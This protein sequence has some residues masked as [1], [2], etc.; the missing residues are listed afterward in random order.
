MK[1]SDDLGKKVYNGEFIVDAVNLI[2]GH[3]ARMLYY[4]NQLLYY[5]Y[6]NLF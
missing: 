6:Y 5:C 3:I 2:P 4:R 1:N